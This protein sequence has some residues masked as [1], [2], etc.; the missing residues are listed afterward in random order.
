MPYRFPLKQIPFQEHKIKILINRTFKIGEAIRQAA[1]ELRSLLPEDREARKEIN[2]RLANYLRSDRALSL[3]YE[4]FH[5]E[6]ED[7][8][9]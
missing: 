9:D 3:K 1:E 6:I 7:S 5:G 8:G 2:I 4:I